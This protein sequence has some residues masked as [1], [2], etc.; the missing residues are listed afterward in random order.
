MP[1]RSR[2]IQDVIA[3]WS[4]GRQGLLLLAFGAILALAVFWGS[5]PEPLA[6][7]LGVATGWRAGP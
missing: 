3:A 5:V 6:R 7:L 2:T 4:W 1:G